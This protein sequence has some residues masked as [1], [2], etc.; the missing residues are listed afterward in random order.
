[1][2]FVALCVACGIAALLLSDACCM[3][4]RRV[5]RGVLRAAARKAWLVR[6]RWPPC[7]SAPSTSH[8]HVAIRFA[9]IP[10]AVRP[11]PP[12]IAW[13]PKCE[14]ARQTKQAPNPSGHG[15]CVA[16]HLPTCTRVSSTPTERG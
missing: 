5:A 1:M 16:P 6:G 10:A 9:P 12:L 15:R 7:V 14:A 11:I 13:L 4:H 3:M 2:L 8:P